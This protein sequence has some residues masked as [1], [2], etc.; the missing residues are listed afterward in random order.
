MSISDDQ[1]L[2]LLTSM[3][4]SLGR[5]EGTLTATVR[6]HEDRF[7]NIEDTMKSNDTKQWIISAC[8]IPVV[9]GLHYFANK[10]GIKV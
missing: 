9:S 1:T 10:I 7:D 2:E 3:K 8:V 5:I 6:A 4:E